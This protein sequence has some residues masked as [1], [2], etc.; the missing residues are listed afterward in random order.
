MTSTTLTKHKLGHA[1]QMSTMFSPVRKT[2]FL[3]NDHLRWLVGWEQNG[4]FPMIIS[5]NNHVVT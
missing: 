3:P 2:H 5:P 4:H 1:I